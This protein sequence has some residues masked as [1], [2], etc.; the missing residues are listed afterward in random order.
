MFRG[1]TIQSI[2]AAQK[3]ASAGLINWSSIGAGVNLGF[4]GFCFNRRS[5][6][7]GGGGHHGGYGN[8]VG[9]ILGLLGGLFG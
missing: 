9:G 8:G 7:G 4:D 3:V 5:G 2:L 6:G 1:S